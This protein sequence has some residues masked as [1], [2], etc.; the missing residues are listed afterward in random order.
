[1]FRILEDCNATFVL[2]QQHFLEE[3]LENQEERTSNY[4]ATLLK[5]CTAEWLYEQEP[6]QWSSGVSSQR[7]SPE[8]TREGTKPEKDCSSPEEEEIRSK[9]G[10]ELEK[11]EEDKVLDKAQ[12]QDVAFLLYA[13]SG[14]YPLCLTQAVGEL[15]K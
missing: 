8:C 3:L 5:S 13:N 11:A 12:G 9:C 15:L 14:E 6:I 2:S 4:M 10:E 1:M 7:K